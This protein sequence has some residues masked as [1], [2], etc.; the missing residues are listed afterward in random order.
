MEKKYLKK[1]AALLNVNTYGQNT[2]EWT[3][4]DLVHVHNY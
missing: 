4:I 1:T 3:S 2:W